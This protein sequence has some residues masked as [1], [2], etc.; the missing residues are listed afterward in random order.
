MS[1]YDWRL[2]VR[3]V[4]DRDGWTTGVVDT[5]SFELRSNALYGGIYG[6]D[7]AA[8]TAWDMFRPLLSAGDTAYITVCAIDGSEYQQYRYSGGEK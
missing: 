3:I 2:Q 7:T 1:N 8:L 5:P 6:R 4:R